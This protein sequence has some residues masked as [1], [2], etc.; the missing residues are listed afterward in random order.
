MKVIL[1]SN[2]KKLGK[3]GEVVSVKDGYARNYLFPQKLAL[4]ENEKNL[5]HYN[6]IS[7]ELKIKENEKLEEAK[8]LVSDIKKIKIVF[9]KEADEKDQLY[10]SI[11]KKEIINFLLSNDIKIRSDDI[12]LSNPIRSVGEHQIEINPYQGIV[13]SIIILVKKN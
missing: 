1:T 6:K 4:Q 11:A 10:G 2:I 7:D 13:E 3:I 5:E 12:K 9:N 8:K